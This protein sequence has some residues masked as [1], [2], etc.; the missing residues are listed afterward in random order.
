MHVCICEKEGRKDDLG[1]KGVKEEMDVSFICTA[2]PKLLSN[3][4]EHTFVVKVT[5]H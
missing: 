5:K 2:I 1:F 3:G 4:T